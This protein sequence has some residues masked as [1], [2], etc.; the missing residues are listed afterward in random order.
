[1]SCDQK[2]ILDPS[3]FSLNG[4]EGTPTV[5]VVDMSLIT[6]A[7]HIGYTS[8]D[9]AA[10]P[11]SAVPAGAEI[12]SAYASL[13][14]WLDRQERDQHRHSPLRCVMDAP[15]PEREAFA[16][17][18][19]AP[20]LRGSDVALLE[21]ALWLMRFPR[22]ELFDPM[23]M[24]R[25]GIQPTPTFWRALRLAGENKK[26]EEDEEGKDNGAQWQLRCAGI[27]SVV[28]ALF[29]M[30]D[31]AKADRLCRPCHQ[32]ANEEGHSRYHVAIFTKRDRA[33]FVVD[34]FAAL[35]PIPIDWTTEGTLGMPEPV[36]VSYNDAAPWM[37]AMC[38][39]ADDLG[40][41]LSKSLEHDRL[42]AS[43]AHWREVD[44]SLSAPQIEVIARTDWWHG[45]NSAHAC[46]IARLCATVDRVEDATC[47]QPSSGLAPRLWFLKEVANTIGLSLSEL[48]DDL[49]TES[50]D[51]NPK[52]RDVLHASMLAVRLLRRRSMVLSEGKQVYTF[53]GEERSEA[54]CY[55]PVGTATTMHEKGLIDEV[56]I[57]YRWILVNVMPKKTACTSK[58][59]IEWSMPHLHKKKGTGRHHRITRQRRANKGGRKT[60]RQRRRCASP[61]SEVPESENEVPNSENEGSAMMMMT[62]TERLFEEARASDLYEFENDP[63]FAIPKELLDMFA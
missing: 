38:D 27:A 32:F 18:Q 52:I 10:Y 12:A 3:I 56:G 30:R 6:S 37:Q 14:R 26:R 19:H 29:D 48:K 54:H 60:A 28:H 51:L 35:P 55:V 8:D 46:A 20:E 44:A 13:L 63:D 23:P 5:G 36:V 45:I 58:A 7:S 47:V 39:V 16:R 4:R 62:K 41:R 25:G 2:G 53:T 21:D 61:D 57:E 24:S 42:C 22:D 31:D 15:A 9:I 11:C 17:V 59:C 50:E 40:I 43:R 33:P 49:R 1:M 34:V